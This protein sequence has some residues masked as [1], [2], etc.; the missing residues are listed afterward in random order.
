MNQDTGAS[1]I[2]IQDEEQ[3]LKLS[4]GRKELTAGKYY[5][6]T[7]VEPLIPKAFTPGYYCFLV[8]VLNDNNKEVDA[9][10]D[11][12]NISKE[13]CQAFLNA[14]QLLSPDN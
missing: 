3:K 11:C 4:K 1:P 14:T 12:F 13:Q 5:K 7:K 6:I 2:Y 10:H 9:V 8:Y